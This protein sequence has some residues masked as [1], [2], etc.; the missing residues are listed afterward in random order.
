MAARPPLRDIFR[1]FRRGGAC[2]SRRFSEL[3]HSTLGGRPAGRRAESSRP[4]DVMVHRRRTGQETRPYGAISVVRDMIIATATKPHL[5]L[6]NQMGSQKCRRGE[7]QTRTSTVHRNGF[8]QR[9][10]DPHPLPRLVGTRRGGE[11]EQAGI[12]H[13]IRARWP[14]RNQTRNRILRAG[15]IT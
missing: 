15:N 14:E 1:S 3:L 11:M 2:P 12:L 4:T 7:S 5:S 6:R 9:P 13:R 10:P 8:V